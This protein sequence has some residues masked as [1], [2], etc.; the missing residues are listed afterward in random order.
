[1]STETRTVPQR[2]DLPASK[3]PAAKPQPRR[4]YRASTADRDPFAVLGADPLGD[5]LDAAF[6]AA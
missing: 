1:M 4:P 3:P 2:T 6:G 5:D